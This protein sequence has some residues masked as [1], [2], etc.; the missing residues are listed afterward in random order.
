[1][2]RRDLAA[3]QS[4]NILGGRLFCIR[5]RLASW[6]R[7]GSSRCN[8]Q[9]DSKQFAHACSLGSHAC[10]S[11]QP[12]SNCTTESDPSPYG[13]YATRSRSTRTSIPYMPIRP[14]AFC[15]SRPGQDHT[16]LVG[17]SLPRNER[18]HA[19]TI[20]DID[21]SSARRIVDDHRVV[22]RSYNARDFSVPDLSTIRE[23]QE[24]Q[25]LI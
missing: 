7:P 13:G 20:G 19:A 1:V 14:G 5:P 15:Y 21:D 22:Y 10:S 11:T 16:T 17:R 18:Y 4:R 2:R 9:S 23:L 6:S 24:I 3:G 25:T 12:S 8:R